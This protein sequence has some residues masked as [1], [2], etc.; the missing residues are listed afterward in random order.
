M[1]FSTSSLSNVAFT[2]WHCHS[3]PFM[4]FNTICGHSTMSYKFRASNGPTR[5]NFVFSRYWKSANDVW[6]IHVTNN[7]SNM[8]Y[9]STSPHLKPKFPHHFSMSSA[10]NRFLLPMQ[11]WS[12]KTNECFQDGFF[13]ST[14]KGWWTWKPGRPKPGEPRGFCPWVVMDEYTQS[15]KLN[16]HSNPF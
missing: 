15:T 11:G 9:L 12:P 14:G 3:M 13:S 4:P 6:H 8:Q 10:E 7:L 5:G 2:A 1:G 16:R